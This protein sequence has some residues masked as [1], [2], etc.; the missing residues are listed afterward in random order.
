MRKHI[1]EKNGN[2]IY[3][4]HLPL[5]TK[6]RLLPPGGQ[7]S[8]AAV[9]TPQWR[10]PKDRWRI[11][12]MDLME[13]RLDFTDPWKNH[14]T[15]RTYDFTN[16]FRSKKYE[17]PWHLHH[18]PHIGT[19]KLLSHRDLGRFWWW[20]WAIGEDWDLLDNEVNLI[21]FFVGIFWW[22]YYGNRWY[23]ATPENQRET[24]QLVNSSRV[25]DFDCNTRF[26]FRSKHTPS[27]RHTLQ[28]PAMFQ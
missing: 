24:V 4:Q 19:A 21:F 12:S 28:Q 27:F 20:N 16:H 5:P 9:G 3:Q 14:L 26:I 25:A 1:W 10:T 7:T 2:K 22:K 11:T 6:S 8:V 18:G 23:W 15:P 17:D 13:P